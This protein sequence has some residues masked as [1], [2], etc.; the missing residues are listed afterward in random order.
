[1]YPIK[2]GADVG[3]TRVI[4]LIA[5]MSSCVGAAPQLQPEDAAFARVVRIY[6]VIRDGYAEPVDMSALA[7]AALDAVRK[8]AGL[9]A[10]P[11]SYCAGRES[12]APRGS[13]PAGLA[14][15]AQAFRC[16]TVPE[17]SQSGDAD[18][19]A[20]A[21]ISAM[22]SRLDK[23]THW[24]SAREIAELNPKS[25]GNA[26]VGLTLQ[27]QPGGFVVVGS[28][29]T[30]P[31]AQAGIEDGDKIAAIDGLG[32]AGLQLSQVVDKMRGVEG[33]SLT[34]TVQRGTEPTRDV[35]LIRK[36]IPAIDLALA[37]ERRGSVLI[38]HLHSLPSAI[39]D[40]VNARI[41]EQG[42]G[43][44]GI[45]LDLRDNAGGRLDQAIE[46]ADL[47][48]D[49]GVIVTSRGRS[50]RDVETYRARKGQ[51][52]AGIPLVVLV[53]HA[54]A[55]GA[56]IIAAAL[57][58]NKRAIILGEKTLAVGTVQTLFPLPNKSALRMTTSYEYR[59]N[60]QRLVDAPVMP[61]CPSNATPAALLN[62]AVEVAPKG[63]ASCP[64]RGAP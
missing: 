51:V 42:S 9:D 30:T 48:L 53:N 54:T 39:A 41:S 3:R 11:S 32:T 28:L 62:D 15:V 20:D 6:D 25:N 43:M 1:M 5:M 8:R 64:S 7:Q 31:A 57:Q 2:A 63:S 33:S 35:T 4:G 60:G 36:I 16:A 46:L 34:L 52:A 40:A 22:A 17:R 12:A 26:F 10:Q 47:F 24:Y 49:K 29:P 45:I 14:G 50:E 55:A 21:A 37:I 18:E 56:E 23:S 59:A 27:E 58:D 44:T 19:L 13:I 61:D 38:L